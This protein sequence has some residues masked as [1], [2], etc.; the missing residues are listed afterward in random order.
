MEKLICATCGKEHATKPG[1][2]R[3]IRIEHEK[4]AIPKSLMGDKCDYVV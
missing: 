4:G 1:L 3:H 2:E